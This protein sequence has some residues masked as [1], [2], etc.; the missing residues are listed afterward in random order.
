M[1][2]STPILT[3]DCRTACLRFFHQEI[4]QVRAHQ[5]IE[6]DSD[7]QFMSVVP[8]KLG[9]DHSCTHLVEQQNIPF[10]HEAHTKLN[11]P[12][13]PIGYLMHMPVLS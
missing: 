2:E 8:S 11:A 10:G 1:C 5:D 12:A 9:R 6:I 4:Q 3:D 7:L 13:F